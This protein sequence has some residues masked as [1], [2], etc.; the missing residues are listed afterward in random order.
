[1]KTLKKLVHIV[2]KANYGHTKAESLIL[3]GPYSNP[4]P[5][6]FIE[7]RPDSGKTDH[8]LSVD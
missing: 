5:N 2:H 8:V 7:A 6:N 4:N 1:M 3:C